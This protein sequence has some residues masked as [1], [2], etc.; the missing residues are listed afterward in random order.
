MINKQSKV[1][2]SKLA[3]QSFLAYGAK[4]GRQDSRSLTLL[5]CG[6]VI[7]PMIC[8]QVVVYSRGG[9]SEDGMLAR[10]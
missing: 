2:A 7:S 6:T 8:G 1:S 5:S 9:D 10:R 4:T 3:Q